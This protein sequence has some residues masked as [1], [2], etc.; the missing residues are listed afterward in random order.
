MEKS[1]DLLVY[2]WPQKWQKMAGFS[3]ENLQ[4][5]EAFSIFV[6]GISDFW[7]LQIQKLLIT[8]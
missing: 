1:M 5:V 8:P 4:I 7:I 6:G 2:F 3:I